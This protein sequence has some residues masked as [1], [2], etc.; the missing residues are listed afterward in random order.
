MA[1]IRKIEGKNGISFKITVTAG[2]DLNGKQ[3][4][5]YKTWTP[6]PGMTEKK[7]QKAVERVA[8]EF[9]QSIE[10][11]YQADNRQTFAEYAAYTLDLKLRTGKL[12]IR[13]YDRYMGLLVR[14]NQ[15]IGHLKLSEI[16]PQHLNLFY[17]RAF[18][19]PRARQSPKPIWPV[20]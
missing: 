6:D 5:H 17:K 10:L 20:C 13:T 19:E 1:N 4:R 12:K 9:E 11:G 7:M 2:R 16:R 3:V 14:I 15:G 18:A 8:M